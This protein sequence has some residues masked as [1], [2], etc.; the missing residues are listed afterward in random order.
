MNCCQEFS[1]FGMF[2]PEGAVAVNSPRLGCVSGVCV[3]VC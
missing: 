3:F 1:T 2:A